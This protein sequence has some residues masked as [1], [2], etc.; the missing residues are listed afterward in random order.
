MQ[1]DAHIHFFTRSL[2]SENAGRFLSVVRAAY[3]AQGLIH[4]QE[5]SRKADPAALARFL[6]DGL[7][8]DPQKILD[9]LDLVYGPFWQYVPLMMDLDYAMDGGEEES[10]E[11]EPNVDYPKNPEFDTGLRRRT[12]RQVEEAWKSVFGDRFEWSSFEWGARKLLVSNSFET[13]RAELVALKAANP[14]RVFPFL[15]IDP[16]RE[17]RDGI[18]LVELVGDYVGPGRPFAGIKLYTSSGFSPTDPA[19]YGSGGLYAHCQKHHVPITLHFGS[20]GFATPASSVVVRGDIFH[21]LSGEAVPVESVYPDNRVRFTTPM[22]P[23]KID[24]AVAERQ[25]LLNHPRLWEKV[26][27]TWPNLF[28]NFAHAGG[29]VQAAEYLRHRLP[30]WT[31]WVLGQAIRYPNVYV[32][33]SGYCDVDVSL[34]DFIS[35]LHEHHSRLRPRLLYGS[36]YFLSQLKDPDLAAYRDRHRN[37]AGSWWKRYSGKNSRRFLRGGIEKKRLFLR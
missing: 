3:L 6:E 19:L 21:P 33:L 24:R 17:H 26:L 20:G 10:D 32:D 22:S 29:P 23:H 35:I 9:S 1:I 8:A 16:R 14:D 34:T 13:Q 11:P 36:D 28:I 37:A 18:S 15:G 7:F 5:R 12:W 31:S 25:M 30:N 27:Q 4:R 2:L